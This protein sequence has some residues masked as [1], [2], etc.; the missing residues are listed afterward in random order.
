MYSHT[1]YSYDGRVCSGTSDALHG[2]NQRRVSRNI[3]YFPSSAPRTKK[4][5]RGC[6]FF[7]FKK[8]GRPSAATAVS[9]VLLPHRVF[10]RGDFPPQAN[11]LLLRQPFHSAHAFVASDNKDATIRTGGYDVHRGVNRQR[12]LS[13]G[14]SA[15]DAL[16]PGCTPRDVVFFAS[17]VGM[18]Q[19]EVN[20]KMAKGGGVR[21]HRR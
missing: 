11:G 10:P 16:T 3:Q 18:I 7:I 6:S 20:E 13:S 5:T 15:C 17:L 12:G 9:D 2:D 14:S 1:P 19:P 21:S 8:W 4:K